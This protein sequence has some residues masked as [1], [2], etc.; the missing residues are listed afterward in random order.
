MKENKKS[1]YG[2]SLIELLIA[3]SIVATISA[4]A[5]VGYQKVNIESRKETVKN[6]LIIA[7]ETFK[8]YGS[9]NLYDD[10]F[11]SGG[12]DINAIYDTNGLMAMQISELGL[13][14]DSFQDYG[15]QGVFNNVVYMNK[16][17]G[18]NYI[19]PKN[20]VISEVPKE[21]CPYILDSWQNYQGIKVRKSVDYCANSY[22]AQGKDRVGLTFNF[23]DV[24]DF[25]MQ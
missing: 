11:M 19:N 12:N 4:L 1:R 8:K 16:Y 10:S 5:F 15:S 17:G 14:Q 9:P 18:K 6:D 20:M 24:E 7:Y 3:L 25:K 13:N 21:I 23:I 22:Y 2:F